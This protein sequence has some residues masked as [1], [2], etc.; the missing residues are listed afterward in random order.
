MKNGTLQHLK[1]LTQKKND[2]Y[3]MFTNNE[4]DNLNFMWN[5]F[6]MNM[7]ISN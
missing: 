3:G 6:K 1:L 7:P 4:I 5:R 2:E